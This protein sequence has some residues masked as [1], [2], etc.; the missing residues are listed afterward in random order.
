VQCNGKVA[1]LLRSGEATL[2]IASLQ[3][4]LLLGHG[5]FPLQLFVN[6]PTTGL[7]P[8]S[9]ALFE[10]PPVLQLLKSFQTFYGT[11]RFIAVFIRP[12]HPF[13]SG[14]RSIQWVSLHPVSL[15]SILILSTHLRLGLPSGLFPSR[16]RTNILYAFFAPIHATCPARLLL[17]DFWR[18]VQVT[19]LFIMQFSSTPCHS[20]SLRSNHSRQ[21]PVL[22]QLYL[23]FTLVPTTGHYKVSYWVPSVK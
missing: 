4:S 11:P 7:T 10:K 23:H 9:W 8:W 12:L 22:G 16:F 20:I 17:L 6:R 1:C 19:K 21:H 13:L 15:R 3:E 5:G 18:R 14:A 2:R